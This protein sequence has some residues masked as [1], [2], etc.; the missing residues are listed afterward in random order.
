MK[1]IPITW[2]D[3]F[4]APQASDELYST[5][6]PQVLDFLK[7]FI[8]RKGYIPQAD[9]IKFLKDRIP[10]KSKKIAPLI[11][12]DFIENNQR[13]LVFRGGSFIVLLR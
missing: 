5:A 1:Q 8:F 6:G 4:L 13:Q 3:E 10:F 7:H 11:E 12:I 2:I 9:R